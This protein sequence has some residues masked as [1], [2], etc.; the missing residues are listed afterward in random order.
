MNS[1]QIIVIRKDLNMRV[2]KIAAQ[3]SHASIAFLTKS[4]HMILGDTNSED[5]FNNGSFS[6]EH[7]HVVKHWLENSV[8]KIVCYVKSEVELEELYEKA[9]EAGLIAHLVIDNGATEFHNVPTKTCI[10]IG[11]AWDY[12]LEGVTNHLQLL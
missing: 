2:G 9:I 12:Q 1:K 5:S 10:A 3:A 8:R 4:G 11:P 7:A 6:S